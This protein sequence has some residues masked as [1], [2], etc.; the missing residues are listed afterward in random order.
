MKSKK[1]F[2]IILLVIVVAVLILNPI[3]LMVIGVFV[4]MVGIKFTEAKLQKPA[5][6]QPVAARL[7][8]YCQSDQNLFPEILSFA[9]LPPEV[10]HLGHPW[11]E[12]RTNFASVEF[13]GGFY[14]FGY[15]LERNEAA[16]TPATNVWE[17]SLAREESP[18][19][20][21]MTLR[22]ASSQHYTAADLEKLVG[23]SFNQTIE[24]G[25]V[26]AYRSKIMLQLKFGQISEAAAT[27][28]DWIKAEPDSWLPR[29]TCVHIQCRLGNTNSASEFS[30]WIHLHKDFPNCICLALFY[31]REGW[32]NQAVDAVRLALAQPL[33]ES[34]STASKFYLGEN[35][36][37][38]AFSAADYDLCQSVCDKMLADSDQQLWWR[39]KALRTRSAA[40]FMK[41]DKSAA[42]ELMKQA[43]NA[44]APDPFSHEP[45]ANADKALLDAIQSN[46]TDFVKNFQNWVD[47]L[48]SWFSP[49]E[50]DESGFHGGNLKIATPYPSSW[51]SDEMTTIFWN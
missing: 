38:I 29:F 27:C 9:W 26:G 8:T 46:N 12:V 42:I 22:L 28:A 7:A 11:C 15:A 31:Y 45:A 48:E 24:N 33:T 51:K 34:D 47:G 41:G 6:Y 44:N 32:T 18:E 23:A 39:R 40:V 4:G 19:I 17:L 2:W 30:D 49:F 14:H 36:A 50:T 3:G 10:S 25:K 5:I 13:G 35:G 21:L 43:E 37:L 16:S 1:K 20:P